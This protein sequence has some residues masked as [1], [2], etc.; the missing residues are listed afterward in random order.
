MSFI[1][2]ALRRADAQRERG[3][4]PGLHSQSV[5]TPAPAAPAP[6][7]RASVVAMLGALCALLTVAVVA[8]WWLREPAQVPAPLAAPAPV[9][10]ASS[11]VLATA[12]ASAPPASA[13]AP[14]A[15][16]PAPV[17]PAPAQKPPP[18]TRNDPAPVARPVIAPAP[19]VARP[20]AASAASTPASAAARLLA[21]SELPEPWRSTVARLGVSGAV[22]SSDPTQSFVMVGGQLAHEGDRVAP[23]V[24]IERIGAH[25]TVLRAGPHRVEI[26]Y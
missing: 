5:A 12:P 8:Q 25:A 14:T 21:P 22:H 17:S 1:L 23:E 3:Q 20:K 13:A 18:V 19:R 26:R 15:S 11:P 4:V 6:R 24:S 9:S 7:S 2:D 10:L 16:A